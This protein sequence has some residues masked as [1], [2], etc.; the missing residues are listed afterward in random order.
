MTLPELKQ[1]VIDRWLSAYDE[2][3]PTVAHTFKKVYAPKK[4]FDL[5]DYEKDQF[6]ELRTL[7]TEKLPFIYTLDESGR[8]CYFEHHREDKISKKGYY[9]YTDSLVEYI[10]YDIKTAAPHC[11]QRIIY[12]GDKKISFQSIMINGAIDPE[13]HG[14]TKDVIIQNLLKNEYALLYGFELYH[15]TD[16][17]ISHTDCLYLSLGSGEY[18]LQK[19]YNYNEAGELVEIM[20]IYPDDKV[21]YGYVK[22]PDNITL[23]ELSDQVATMIAADII[24]TLKK[25]ETPVPVGILE[26]DFQEVG[27]FSPLLSVFSEQQ[28]EEIEALEGEERTTALFSFDLEYITVAPRSFDRLL[29]AFMRETD[30]LE[31]YALAIAMARKTAWLLNNNKLN[32]EIPVTKKFMAYATDWDVEPE[33]FAG[34]LKDCGLPEKEVEK[35]RMD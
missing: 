19:K 21:L 13:F 12:D 11:I 26:I 29:C 9:T 16:N 27:V 33:D 6:K 24:E 25:A 20:D 5:S 14:T 34:V 1:D 30:T 35:W 10:E 22:T 8:P 4:R 17:R 3:I 28:Q 2:S 15:Y 31:N 23:Q 18:T 32:N 7:S